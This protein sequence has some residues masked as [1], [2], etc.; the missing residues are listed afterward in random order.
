MAASGSRWTQLTGATL[1][2]GPLL[3]HGRG[4]RR[5]HLRHR[6]LLLDGA[7]LVSVATVE[8]LNPADAVPSWNDAAVADLPEVCSESRAWGFD[9]GSLYEDPSDNTSLSGTIISACGVWAL[10]VASVYAYTAA[11]NTWATFPALAIARRSQAAEFLPLA[12]APALWLWGGYVDDGTGAAV[13]TNTVEYYS[14]AT[15]PGRAAELQHRV[16]DS[17]RQ[18]DTPA[19]AG[20]GVAFEPDLLS[21]ELC[22]R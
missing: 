16:T 22:R 14:L 1:T 6:R 12:G 13:E 10:P 9:T 8:V 11:T 4:G 15:G 21:G 2:T 20:A 19:P 7:G 5:P 3:H 18:A 17:R